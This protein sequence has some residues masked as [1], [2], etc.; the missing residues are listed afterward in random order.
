M[1][2]L[3]HIVGLAFAVVVLCT[4]VVAFPLLLDRDVGAY[5]AV[6]T[7]AHAVLV[8]PVPMLAWGLFVTV[9]LMV[10]SAPLLAGLAV[11][12]PILGHATWHVYR[13]VVEPSPETARPI[14]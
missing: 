12:L 13:K 7:S 4:T 14:T 11:V 9:L 8:N 1:I 3:G 2:I 6:Y 10:G 5:E